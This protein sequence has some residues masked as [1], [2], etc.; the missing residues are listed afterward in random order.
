[1]PRRDLCH[2]SAGF[3]SRS[4]QH[5]DRLFK[6]RHVHHPMFD[7][8]MDSNLVD[9]LPNAR[10]GFPVGWHQTTLDSAQF[11]AGSPPSFW[12]IRH[13]GQHTSGCIAPQEAGC[14]RAETG[15]A[16]LVPNL[17]YS[18]GALKQPCAWTEARPQTLRSDRHTDARDGERGCASPADG[19]P[20]SGP[21]RVE[22]RH[23]RET[24]YPYLARRA[25]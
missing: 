8:R 5:V 4:V 12:L 3:S 15:P 21:S 25:P 9:T 16:T 18:P 24:S 14:R 13:G 11:V 6:L 7:I 23:G 2:E 19:V 10:Y 1:V 22:W 20:I 17:R